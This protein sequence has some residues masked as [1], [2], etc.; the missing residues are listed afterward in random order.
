MS[1]GKPGVPVK[2]DQTPCLELLSPSLE[3]LCPT[4]SPPSVLP[5]H[6]LQALLE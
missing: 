1:L 4:R 5:D 2:V 6:F 3:E